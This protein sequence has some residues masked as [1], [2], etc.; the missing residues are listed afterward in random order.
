L[1]TEDLKEIIAGYKKLITEKKG[2][3]FPQEVQ[4]QLQQAI[5]AVFGSWNRPRAI[6]YININ[7]IPHT[8]GTAVNIV[9]MVF[10]NMGDTSA[11]GVAFKRNPIIFFFRIIINF[12]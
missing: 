6:T 12:N 7:D 11:T 5:H 9:A 10:G 3:E 1:K 4:E 2:H 8:W